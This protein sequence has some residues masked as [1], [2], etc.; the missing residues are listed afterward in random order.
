MTPE[1]VRRPRF[2][3]F[4]HRGNPFVNFLVFVGGLLLWFILIILFL[5]GLYM[6]WFGRS[7]EYLLGAIHTKKSYRVPFW[8]SAILTILFFPITLILILVAAFV[9][10][11]RD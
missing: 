1:V 7:L 10:I 8:F 9:K 4:E 6:N 2:P 3:E 5:V 11:I